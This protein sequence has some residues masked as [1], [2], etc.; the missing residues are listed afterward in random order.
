MDFLFRGRDVAVT[1]NSVKILHAVRSDITAIAGLL[2]YKRLRNTLTYTYLLTY[3]L[4]SVWRWCKSC[5]CTDNVRFVDTY[6]VQ[7]PV[8]RYS[9][10][11]AN[12]MNDADLV[13]FMASLTTVT[14]SMDWRRS[15]THKI[16]PSGQHALRLQR[17]ALYRCHRWW[18]W[19]RRRWWHRVAGKDW[20]EPAYR[21]RECSLFVT[22]HHRLPL[23]L[24]P[25]A[26]V[27]RGDPVKLLASLFRV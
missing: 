22:E 12:L 23:R 2:V 8:M 5:N 15:S 14:C 19:W 24:G 27:K 21:L 4:R 3:L 7:Q 9:A 10:S 1:M 20:P 25:N 18:W 16:D 13:G 26:R 11:A 6:V 17:L